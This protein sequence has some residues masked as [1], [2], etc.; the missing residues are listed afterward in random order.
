[1]Q[2]P[3]PPDSGQQHKPY[4]RDLGEYGEFRLL[5]DSD[6]VE[7]VLMSLDLAP[8]IASFE[9]HTGHDF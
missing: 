5:K 9:M 8:F 4:Y 7:M 6:K 2:H 1:M 3:L